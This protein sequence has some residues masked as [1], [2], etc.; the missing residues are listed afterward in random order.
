MVCDTHA[1]VFHGPALLSTGGY[2]RKTYFTLL[3][4]SFT[5]LYLTNIAWYVGVHFY[6]CL[7]GNVCHTAVTDISF[8]FTKNDNFN[9]LLVLMHF[10]FSLF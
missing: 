4:Q 2:E 7:C 1:T 9:D 10:G 5:M 8:F 6:R 3:S